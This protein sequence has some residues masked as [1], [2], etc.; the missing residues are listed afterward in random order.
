MLNQRFNCQK[1]SLQT[2]YT[3][4]VTL[5]RSLRLQ[6]ARQQAISS[7]RGSTSKHW[8]DEEG[9][10]SGNLYYGKPRLNTHAMRN[11]RN[12]ASGCKTPKYNCSA[13]LQNRYR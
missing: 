8:R 5:P 9:L 11:L 12:A 1:G 6:Q 7:G 2:L 3:D 10:H 13:A 4:T